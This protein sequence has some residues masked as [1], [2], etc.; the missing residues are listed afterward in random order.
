MS[1]GMNPPNGVEKFSAENIE[2]CENYVCLMQRK[3]DKA[4]ANDDKR[5]IRWYTDLLI[6]KSEAVRILAVHNVASNKGKYTAGVDG[7][8]LLGP[9]IA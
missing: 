3:L 9:Y 2:E 4:V 1:K 5:K 8:R 7:V 6:N